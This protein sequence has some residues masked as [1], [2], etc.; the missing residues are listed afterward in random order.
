[1]N[2][3]ERSRSDLSRILCFGLLHRDAQT[4]QGY[5]GLILKVLGASGVEFEA[6]K[7]REWRLCGSDL[8]LGCPGSRR[9]NFEDWFV[10]VKLPSSI[11][12]LTFKKIHHSSKSNFL[13]NMFD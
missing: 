2:S 1:M 4:F 5:I 10:W 8:V 7:P 11:F 13:R 3:L 12:Q 9:S 6:L